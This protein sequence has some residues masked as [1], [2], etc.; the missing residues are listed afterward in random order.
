MDE[1]QNL[2]ILLETW[3]HRLELNGTRAEGV[4][5]RTKDG[6]EILVR[7]RNEVLLCAGAVDSPAC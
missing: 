3:A 2:T 5:V 4:H 1:R 7:A 6:E